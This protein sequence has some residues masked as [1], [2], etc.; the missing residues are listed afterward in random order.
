MSKQILLLLIHLQQQSLLIPTPFPALVQN[1][2]QHSRDIEWDEEGWHYT[3]SHIDDPKLRNE[4]VALY[5]LAL[6]A[7]NFCFWPH[8]STLEYHHL[9]MALTQLAN[10]NTST[11]CDEEFFFRPTNL[12]NM[13]VTQMQEC[14]RTSSYIPTSCPTSRN[15]VACGMNS[16]RDCWN[17]TM[18]KHLNLIEASGGNAPRL[19]Q[20]VISSFAGFRDETIYEKGMD[21]PFTSV[22]K[23][24]SPT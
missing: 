15:D 2:H 13:T 19:V 14:T 21:V 23:L 8:D 4:H 3:G 7:I 22:L 20:L 1:M 16:V 12:A 10:N 6:D 5:I 24:P 9:A 18:D 17:F 11:T